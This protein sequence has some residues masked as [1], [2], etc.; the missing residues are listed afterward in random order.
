MRAK[1]ITFLCF[2]LTG[3]TTSVDRAGYVQPDTVDTGKRVV[4]HRVTNI[5]QIDPLHRE[6]IWAFALPEGTICH[7]FIEQKE[8]DALIL[9]HELRHCGGWKH[10]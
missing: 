3:C 7:V 9:L 1:A 6:H 5:Q 8:R 10:G 2:L 4:V